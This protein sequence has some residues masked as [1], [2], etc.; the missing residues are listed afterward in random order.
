MKSKN[1]YI[2][3]LSTLL[4]GIT[5]IKSMAL[6]K[7]HL[8]KTSTTPHSLK[9][10][11][12][13][14]FDL[15]QIPQTDQELEQSRINCLSFADTSSF[16]VDDCDLDDCDN[17]LGPIIPSPSAPAKKPILSK[18]NDEEYQRYLKHY[19]SKKQ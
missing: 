5:T 10:F 15:P 17:L 18:K 2:I 9:T 19:L 1:Y 12:Y 14:V 8:A 6:Y 13:P 4:L 7:K 3:A 16:D 11:V